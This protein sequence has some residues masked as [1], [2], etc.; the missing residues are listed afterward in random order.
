MHLRCEAVKNLDLQCALVSLLLAPS[1]HHWGGFEL[2]LKNDFFSQLLETRIVLLFKQ[3]LLVLNDLHKVQGCL[4]GIS[5]HSNF[6]GKLVNIVLESCV[7]G[8]EFFLRSVTCVKLLFD[9]IIIVNLL[10]VLHFD[11]VQLLHYLLILFLVV[12]HHV[13]P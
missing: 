8:K 7:V 13:L 3:L 4:I 5:Q 1:Y 10:V 9:V 2:L 11:I 6:V 12:L